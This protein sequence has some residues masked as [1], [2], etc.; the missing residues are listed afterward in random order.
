M[1]NFYIK[2]C[3]GYVGSEP[4]IVCS[5]TYVVILSSFSSITTVAPAEKKLAPCL[6]WRV[7]TVNAKA[8]SW[9]LAVLKKTLHLLQTIRDAMEKDKTRV[10]GDLNAFFGH[11]PSPIVIGDFEGNR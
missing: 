4:G 6:S 8:R 10:T 2:G 3:K 11:K 5:I 9:R 1:Y 7:A